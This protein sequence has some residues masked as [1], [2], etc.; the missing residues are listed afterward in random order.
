MTRLHLSPRATALA[1]LLLLGLSACSAPPPD[2]GINDPYENVN[3]ASHAL[4]KGADR[5]FFR[6]ASQAYGK[7]VPNPV[8]RSLSNVA[9]NLDEPRTF[10]NHIVQGDL[11]DAGHTFFRFAINTTIGVFGL[12]G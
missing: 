3:R 7:V 12:F 8:R 5:A 2:G 9:S 11:G 6:P 10:V 4:N 1:A